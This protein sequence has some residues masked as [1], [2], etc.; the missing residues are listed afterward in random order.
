[1][2]NY[3]YSCVSELSTENVCRNNYCI[4]D[5]LFCFVFLVVLVFCPLVMGYC[6]NQKPTSC[7][8]IPFQSGDPINTTHVFEKL[9]HSILDATQNVTVYMGQTAVFALQIE[10]PEKESSITV[11]A[12]VNNCKEDTACELV[13][14]GTIIS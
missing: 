1:M 4:V 10:R 8:L 5:M 2:H 9:A 3:A 12:Y 6:N 13:E 14:N 11:A 7:K